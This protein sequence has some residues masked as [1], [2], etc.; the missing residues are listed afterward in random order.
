MKKFIINIKYSWGDE[1]EPIIVETD[2]KED[3]FNHMIDLA[4]KEIKETTKEHDE[5]IF[6]RIFPQDFDILLDYG[7]DGEQCYYELKEEE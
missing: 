5:D 7:Y 2:N 6:I 3:A 1:E 4:V